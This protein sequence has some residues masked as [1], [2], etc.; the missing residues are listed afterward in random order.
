MHSC[1]RSFFLKSKKLLVLNV[2]GRWCYFP[3]STVLQGNDKVFRKNVNM[4]KVE[5]RVG[6]N[7]FQQGISKVSYHNLVLYETWGCV[8]SSSHVHA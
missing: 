1:L 6:G 2:N 4:T 8:R 7:F 3:P 5:V